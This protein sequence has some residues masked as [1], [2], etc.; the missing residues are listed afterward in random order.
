MSLPEG[1][2]DA[3]RDEEWE[4]LL[5]RYL[6]ALPEQVEIMAGAFESGDMAELEAVAHKVKGT[7][8]T[9]GLS[10]I[11]EAASQVELSAK[12]QESEETHKGIERL[13]Q[14]VQTRVSEL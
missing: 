9:Y 12:S 4:K 11:A 1:S 10:K 14:L 6:G 13:A 3:I 7:A 8:G 2:C 5:T